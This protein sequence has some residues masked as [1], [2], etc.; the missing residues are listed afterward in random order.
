MSHTLRPTFAAIDLAALAHNFSE[1]QRLCGDTAVLAVVKANAYGHGAALCAPALERASASLFG[2]ALVEEGLELRGA[3]VRR[4]IVVLGGPYG[5]FSEVLAHD[6]V[7][8]IYGREQLDA[9]DQA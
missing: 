1:V 6:L 5:D 4:P 7:P 8:V 3:G 9:L 2:V